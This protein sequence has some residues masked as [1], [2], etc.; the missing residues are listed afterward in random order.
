MPVSKSDCV[1]HGFLRRR[2]IKE[3]QKP[4]EPTKTHKIKS[5]NGRNKLTVRFVL[6]VPVTRP[7]MISGTTTPRSLN[8]LVE[9]K[10]MKL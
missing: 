9:Y 1:T 10:L 8:I 6:I 2:K 5:S 7:Q 4:F 3:I